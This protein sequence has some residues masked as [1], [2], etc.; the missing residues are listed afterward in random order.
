MDVAFGLVILLKTVIS[1]QQSNSNEFNWIFYKK[2]KKLRPNLYC[3]IIVSYKQH[4]IL[5]LF[6]TVF[7]EDTTIIGTSIVWKYITINN[8]DYMCVLENPNMIINKYDHKLL[9]P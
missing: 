5:Q 8:Y 6:V 3:N 4:W 9:S 7:Y 2:I 1:I